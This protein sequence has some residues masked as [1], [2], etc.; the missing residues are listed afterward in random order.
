MKNCILLLQLMCIIR[1]SLVIIH[2]RCLLAL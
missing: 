1:V 2:C